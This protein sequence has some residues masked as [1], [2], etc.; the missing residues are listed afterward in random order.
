MY[1][2][3]YQIDVLK[4]NRHLQWLRYGPFGREEACMVLGTRGTVIE[5]I[6]KE[7]THFRRWPY[8]QNPPT[9]CPL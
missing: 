3:Q 9:P 2:E 5:W 6:R 4:V 1:T 8:G 7:E